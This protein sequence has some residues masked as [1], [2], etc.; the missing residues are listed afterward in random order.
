[1]SRKEVEM[2]ERR[3]GWRQRRRV[4]WW[5]FV[6]YLWNATLM[7][8]CCEYMVFNS[9]LFGELGFLIPA[10]GYGFLIAL[11]LVWKRFG[12]WLLQT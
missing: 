11:P 9:G 2:E 6:L 12:T 7:F 3:R 1:M 10:I 8:V 5:P 4:T